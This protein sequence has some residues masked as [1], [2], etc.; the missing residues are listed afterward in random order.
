VTDKND[1]KKED[2]K[3]EKKDDDR[4]QDRDMIRASP[5]MW[6]EPSVR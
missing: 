4:I 5:G 2:K 6:R 3:T 1:D